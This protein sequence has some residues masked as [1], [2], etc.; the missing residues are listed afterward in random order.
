[1]PPQYACH[2]ILQGATMT[3]SKD[4]AIS[5]ID[6]KIVQFQ[7]VSKNATYQNRYDEPYQLAYNGSET[8]LTELFSKEEAMDFRG[9]VT[10]VVFLAGGPI[11]YA[12][13]LADYREHIARCIARLKVY[14][15]RILNFWPDSAIESATKSASVP[16]VSM[17]FDDSDREINEY[18]TS[19]L[20]SLR[21]DFETGERYSKESIPEKVQSRIR[22]S[23]LFIII[24]VRRDK[25]EGGGYTTPSWLLKELGL[26]QGARKDVIAFVERGIKDIAGLNYEKQV[27]YFERDSLQSVCKATLVF[28]EA[29][30]EHQLV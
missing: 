2:Y 1:M 10:S 23:D 25:I 9:Q 22:S 28:L 26:A 24:F 20:K 8:L 4:K 21:I 6:A 30:K 29:L 19:I 17:S 15:E 11:N 3:I 12:Q 16:F 7:E 18:F 5:L 27:I 13:E 14:N